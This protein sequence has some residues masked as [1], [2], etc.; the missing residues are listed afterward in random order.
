MRNIFKENIFTKAAPVEDNCRNYDSYTELGNVHL[1]KRMYE[2]RNTEESYAFTI[3]Q[4][5]RFNHMNTLFGLDITGRTIETLAKNLKKHTEVMGGEAFRLQL[6]QFAVFASY[7]NQDRFM[8]ELEQQLQDMEKVHIHD[9]HIT[10]HHHYTFT[11]LVY[12]MKKG[13]FMPELEQIISNME[14][15]VNRIAKLSETN[16]QIFNDSGEPDWELQRILL[17]DV[18]RGWK[19][20]EFVPYYQLIYDVKTKRSIG[21]EL[22]TRWKH[23]NKGIIYPGD[24]I[25]ILE[26][27][28]L[29][30]ELDLYMLEEAC[31]KIQHWINDELV[32]VPITINISKLNLHREKFVQRVI[33]IV[34]KYDIPPVLIN[35][36]MEEGAIIFE[37]DDFFINIMNQ[38]HEYGFSLSMDRFAA[39]EYSSINMLRNIPVDMIKM[40]PRFFP[41]ENG[42]RREKIFV[43]DV[44]RMTKDLGIKAVAENVET[45]DEVERLLKYGCESAQGYFFSKPMSNEEFE[46]VIF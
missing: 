8:R 10:Y 23:P 17:E 5:N 12:F 45:E 15:Q 27:K 14:L 11:Y 43:R 41:E 28:G 24:F 22:L 32:T 13:E 36:E 18:D 29:I 44:F 39:T 6:D 4:L 42:D 33:E 25:P 3:I 26:S 34:E 31:K 7:E 2:E 35:L 16:G 46:K 1:L 30:I 19:E 21:A 9:D 40:N 37:L 38:F 20:K